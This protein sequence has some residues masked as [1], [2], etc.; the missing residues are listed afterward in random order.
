MAADGLKTSKPELTDQQREA[1]RARDVSVALSAGAGCGK[2]FVLTKRFLSHLEPAAPDRARLGQL[3][4]IT[5][6]ER[7]AREMR[8][9]IR[10]EC[11]RRLLECSEEEASYWLDLLRELDSARISTIHSFCGSLLRAHAVEAGLDPRFRVLEQA[12]ADTL[13]S[14]LLDDH[15]RNTLA[16]TGENQALIELVVQYGFEGLGEMIA[17]VLRRRQEIDWQHWRGVSDE[18]L[19][20]IWQ[21]YLERETLP[22]V[23]RQI[24][25]S[26]QAKKVLEI[27][28]QNPS[29]NPVMQEKLTFLAQNLPKLLESADPQAAL[30]QLRAATIIK[31]A[32]SK[33]DWPSE[34]SY[35]EYREAVTA[36]R[37]TVDGLS[38]K[39][40]FDPQKALPAAETGLQVLRLADAVGQAYEREKQEQGVLDF[41][42]LLIHA[43]RLLVGDAQKA[44]RKRWADNLRLLLVDE[45]QDT[46][47]LQVEVVKALCDNELTGGKLFFV[48]D[49]KQSIYRFRGADPRVF[50]Q[51]RE[52]IPAKGRMPLSL[53]FRSQPAILDFVNALFC[54]E[55]AEYEPLEPNRPQIGPTPAVE[56]LWA[57]DADS[58]DGES[59]HPSHRRAPT[60]GWSGE[61]RDSDNQTASER[62][63]RRE[64]DWIAR[65]IRGLLD[66]GERIVWDKEAAKSGTPAARSVQPGDIALLFRA[67]SDVEYYEEALRSYGI[68][69]YLVGGHA[70]YAQQEVF[71]LLSLLRTLESPCDQVSLLGVLRSPFFGLLDET[72]FWLAQHNEG[73]AAG[74]FASPPPSQI[75]AEQRSQVEFAANTLRELRAIKD[76]LPVARLINEA[77]ERSGYDAVL[78]AEFLGER[79]LANLHKLIEQARAVDQS[80][81][82]GLADFI[83]QLAEYVRNQPDEPLAATQS[84][85]M[86]VV[87]LMTIHQAKG[88]EFPI[89]IVPDI[90][91]RER[92]LDARLAFTP[93]L[94]PMVKDADA[95]TGY[96]L[97]AIG[98]K[99]E[100]EAEI[101][102]LLYVAATRAADYLILSSGLKKLG[103]VIGPWMALL[104]RKFDLLTGEALG[105]DLKGKDLRVKI[106]TTKPEVP[107][108][109]SA[110]AR[111]PRLEKIVDK[112]RKKAEKGEGRRPKYLAPIPADEGARRQFSFSRLSGKL[113]ERAAAKRAVLADTDELGE[114]GLDPRGLGTLVHAVLAE[115]DFADPGVFEGIVRRHAAQHLEATAETSI[116]EAVEMIGR[117]LA[118]P[119]AAEIAAADEVHRELEF[120]LAWPPGNREAG[121]R[122]LRGFIDCLYRDADN[123]WRII[124]YKTNRIDA[125]GLEQEAAKY[126]MQ[127]LLYALAAEKLLQSPPMELVLY[128]LYPG[129]EARFS[130]D[131]NARRRVI[132]LINGCLP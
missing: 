33:K 130:W 32:G 109:P 45:F 95:A 98:E 85:T 51:L 106:T 81:M 102:R 17:L 58:P 14:E 40:S 74:L 22:C 125:A 110:A 69:Y 105:G 122:Y 50:R 87:R 92:G 10:S 9:R 20:A 68:D 123:Q 111:R 124:D 61:G 60:E 118:S 127:M 94:G 90:A 112:A 101:T 41:D 55:F 5:F 28:R 15:L 6:T 56:F 77:I 70:F 59:P 89:V 37:K 53:N 72:I 93:Q 18:G 46:D 63:R 36:L 66:S 116:D 121:G 64:A 117:F 27:A 44:L 114:P 75:S 21:G 49:F 16:N 113:Y 35:E 43:K 119:R 42:D 126:E 23:L 100:K 131:D 11:R 84:E 54:D 120:L 3:V 99:E 71:D 115:V 7:A 57:V 48:G 62:M 1:I 83:A 103:D 96:D 108:E 88:L 34:E 86:N 52:Q 104:A 107:R 38:D 13:L 73:L 132:E 78:L 12:Q 97:F 31:G 30:A 91:R 76:R 129:L 29:S 39:I 24:A 65:R 4:A 26:P 82:F 128:F 2:T 67:L 47:P 79:K 25:A 80:D 8:D 19:T